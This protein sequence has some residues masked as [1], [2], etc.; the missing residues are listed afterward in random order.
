MRLLL[1]LPKCRLLL[2]HVTHRQAEDPGRHRC[3]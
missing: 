3:E 2:H 1:G